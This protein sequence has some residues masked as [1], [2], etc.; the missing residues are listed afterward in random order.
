MSMA[1]GTEV[2]IVGGGPV[3][4][5]LAGD[6]GWRG[7]R[8]LLVERGDGQIRQAKMDG[9]GL[10]TMEH[11]RRWGIVKDVE[12]SAYNRAYPQDNVYL[13]TLTGHEMGRQPMPSML[14]DKAP[15]ESPQ[16]RERCPQNMFDPILQRFARSQE[17]V[18]LKYGH[19]LLS[20]NQHADGVA[21]TVRDADG[22]EIVVNSKFL[23]GCDGGRSAV[24]EHLGI[25]MHG[26]G[27][28]THTTNVIFRCPHFNQLHDKQPGY[29]YMFVDA[30]GVW[31][32]IVAINGNDQ[33]RMSIIGNARDNAEYD[34]AQLKQFA[35]AA[36]GRPFDLE[37]LSVL[38][39]TR[40]EQVADSYG[41]G[42]VFIAG[43]ACHL[44]S[45]TGGLGMNTGIG[46]AVDLSWKIAAC[47]EGWGGRALLDSYAIERRP[48]AIR[49]TRFSTSNLETMKQ[50]PHT[51]AIFADGSEGEAARAKVGRALTDGLKKEWFSKNMHLGNR[52]IGS[53]V[54]IYNEAENPAAQQA[55]FDDAVNYRPSTRAGCR[56]PHAWLDDGR[57]MLDLFG[58]GF[59]LVY[60]SVAG[61]DAT[62]LRDA[63]ARRGVPLTLFATDKPEVLALYEKTLVLV[64]PD[65]HVAWRGDRIDRSADEIISI[66]TGNGSAR[67]ES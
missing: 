4:L 11:C 3:G 15:P 30:T 33:W 13:T 18:S 28:L 27:V 5:S 58:R 67:I 24:R 38:R 42:R 14:N 52:Y 45:P 32:T 21:A 17:G 65:G 35:H 62:Q 16:K 60:R 51:E 23:I 36:V 9:V 49:I 40:I 63:A 22:N 50:V 44:T 54:C 1:L 34:E 43:D 19:R 20:F 25:E 66:V 10:R 7:R 57:S 2:L 29:R 47:L 39:W 64:R 48:V 46:D 53:P 31:A 26:R 8:C 61:A 12:S 41:S 56:A 59:V 55:E 37:I 6:L